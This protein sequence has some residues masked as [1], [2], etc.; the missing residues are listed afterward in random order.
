MIGIIVLAAGGSSRLG[1]PKQLL[2]YQGKTLIRRSVEAALQANL[3]PVIVVLG[4]NANVLT[5]HVN[6]LTVSSVNNEQWETGSSSSIRAGLRQAL[7]IQPGMSAAVFTLCDQPLVTS[8]D[9]ISLGERFRSNNAP[10]VASAY[11]DSFGVPALF[12]R[13]LFG[14]LMKLP[15]DAGAKSII[16]AHIDTA[17]LI[18]LPSAAVDIDS[19]NDYE[20]LIG[21]NGN[22]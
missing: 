11:G 8:N 19:F 5:N 6:D 17:S 16:K 21:A 18:E 3:G 10:I 7:E 15:G 9:L 1:R 12:S 20:K 4:A 14:E 22:K 2:E 13:E